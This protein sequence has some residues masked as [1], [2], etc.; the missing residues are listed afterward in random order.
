MK[1]CGASGML[2]RLGMVSGKDHSCDGSGAPEFSDKDLSLWKAVGFRGRK[3]AGTQRLGGK[4]RT[5]LN[6]YRG[7]IPASALSY[8]FTI[9]NKCSVCCEAG[10]I[11]WLKEFG[12]VCTAA[13]VHVGHGPWT[14]F[15]DVHVLGGYDTVLNRVDVM[16]NIRDSVGL[17]LVSGLSDYEDVLRGHVRDALRNVRVDSG[18]DV[19]FADWVRFRDNWTVP[20]ACNIGKHAILEVRRPGRGVKRA[21]AGGKLGK[22]LCLS[23]QELVRLATERCGAQILPFRKED[24]PVKTRVVFGYDTRSYLRCSYADAFLGDLNAN[25]SW[26]PLGCSVAD[27]AQQR[28]DIWTRLGGSAERAVSLDQS[29]FDLNQPKWA[30]RMAIEEVFNR[31]I[32]CCHPELVEEVTK[33]KELELFAFDEARVGDVCMWGRGVP[34]GHKWTALVDTLLN[35]GECLI[36]AELRGVE[37]VRGLWQGDDGLVFEKGKATMSWADAYDKLGLVVNAAKTWVDST[38]CEFLHE[39]YS[40]SG[41]RAFPARAFRSVCW[42]KPVMGAS[43]FLSGTERLNSRLDVLL[44]CARRG[45]YRMADEAVRMLTKRGLSAVHAKEVLCTSRNLGGLGWSDSMRRALVVKGSEVEYRHVSIVSPVFGSGSSG[46]FSFGALRRLGAHMPLPVSELVVSSRW[47]SPVAE[48][49]VHDR[50]GRDTKLRLNWNFRDPV[51]DPWRRRL[52]MEWMLARGRDWCDALVPDE[53]CRTSP[54]GAERAFRFASRWA[55]ERLNLD[56][57]LTTGESWCVLA[58]LGNRMWMGLVACMVG[59]G[60]VMGMRKIDGY[61]LGLYRRIWRYQ[62]LSKPLFKIRV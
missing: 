53:C 62:V 15:C 21:K 39:F 52:E 55:S 50:L 49:P 44:K 20:G 26:T 25:G 51:S 1:R 11:E 47:V 29:S 33:F 19:A 27:R 31:I 37:V 22:T 34:S 12:R 14:Y 16:A 23:D 7:V 3:T 2:R 58:D 45:L 54:L 8:F 42:D 5:I 57:E 38:S 46:C 56:C 18:M 36:A 24:E 6:R 10:I 41:V 43:S 17:P 59:S 28:I 13:T 61:W 35:R 9:V 48:V 40:A 30:V 4:W 32:D 60:N